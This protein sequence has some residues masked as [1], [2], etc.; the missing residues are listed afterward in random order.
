MEGV[1]S[2]GHMEGRRIVRSSGLVRSSRHQ[3]HGT[4]NWRVLQALCVHAFK[5]LHTSLWISTTKLDIGLLLLRNGIFC[6]L[7]M[8]NSLVYSIALNH[9]HALVALFHMTES[10]RT[11]LGKLV[12]SGGY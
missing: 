7:S 10:Q 2:F 5:M 1:R 11:L 6:S 3:L 4:Q 12:N 9:E 8:L